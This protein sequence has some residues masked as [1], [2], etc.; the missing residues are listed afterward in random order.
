[1]RR[2]MLCACVNVHVERILL[3]LKVPGNAS[4]ANGKYPESCYAFLSHVDDV[5]TVCEF[6]AKAMLSPYPL[7]F[8]MAQWSIIG[9]SHPS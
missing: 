3:L 6:Q 5:I 4:A 9:S 7:G 1:M 8:R 2:L